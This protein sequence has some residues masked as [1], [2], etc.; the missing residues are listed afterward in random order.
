[1]STSPKAPHPI[2]RGPSPVASPQPHPSDGSSGSS[3]HGNYVPSYSPP[4][5]GSMPKTK[6]PEGEHIRIPTS[7]RVGDGGSAAAESE[8][9]WERKRMELWDDKKKRSAQS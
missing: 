5:S 9:S 6:T 2:P 3:P 7:V 8:V 1:M 4:P